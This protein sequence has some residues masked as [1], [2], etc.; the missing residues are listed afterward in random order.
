[1]FKLMSKTKRSKRSASRP[2]TLTKEQRDK[3]ENLW[4]IFGN[5][6]TKYTADNH[7]FI[8]G[9]IERGQDERDFYRPTDECIARVDLILALSTTTY[10]GAPT[11]R[12]V[13]CGKIIENDQQ[14]LQYCEKSNCWQHQRSLCL[15]KTT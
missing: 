14:M 4:F 13:F 7:G 15:E 3:L 12:C 5:H 8:Q 2:V 10:G 1:M 6:R 11:S 9:L